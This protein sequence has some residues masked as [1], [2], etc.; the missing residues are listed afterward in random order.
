M[1][2]TVKT[3]EEFELAIKE[4]VERI[5][6]IEPYAKVII[7]KLKRKK[8]RR[9]WGGSLLIVA[10]IAAAPFTFGASTAGLIAGAG[11]TVTALTITISAAEIAVIFAGII[12]ILSVIKGA[13]IKWDYANNIIVVEPNYKSS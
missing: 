11:L 2:R 3:K 12:G 6:V 1:E 5:I 7:D 10:S 8:K 4:R 9:I 13:K